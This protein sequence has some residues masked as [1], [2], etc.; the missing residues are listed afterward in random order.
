MTTVDPILL[1]S[2]SLS[3][4]F[5]SMVDDDVRSNALRELSSRII[6]ARENAARASA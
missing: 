2:P 3:T 4:S 6:G 1:S 5:L